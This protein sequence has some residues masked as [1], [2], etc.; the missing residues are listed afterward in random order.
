MGQN[1]G[2]VVLL[3]CARGS[4]LVMVYLDWQAAIDSNERLQPVCAKSCGRSDA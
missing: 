1:K 3:G 4:G 2:M